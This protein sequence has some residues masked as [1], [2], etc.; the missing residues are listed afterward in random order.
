VL[1]PYLD[2]EVGTWDSVDISGEI[3]L[4]VNLC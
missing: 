4:T 3:V 2:K 1:K